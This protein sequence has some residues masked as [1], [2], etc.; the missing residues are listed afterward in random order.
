MMLHRPAARKWHG[1]RQQLKHLLERGR[2][3]RLVDQL[4]NSSHV[5]LGRGLGLFQRSETP[6]QLDV[7]V[8]GGFAFFLGKE[9]TKLLL[10][11]AN[12]ILRWLNCF[13]CVSFFHKV[14]S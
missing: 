7:L 3:G 13:L 12:D 6:G 4:K 11:S 5:F 1:S 10:F 2:P 14:C 9:L 8:I